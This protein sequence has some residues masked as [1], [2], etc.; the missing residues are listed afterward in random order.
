MLIDAI[1]CA[2]DYSGK[3]AIGRKRDF[4]DDWLNASRQNGQRRG[5]KA[6]RKLSDNQIRWI[7]SQCGKLSQ[8]EMGRRLNVSDPLPKSHRS[9]NH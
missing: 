9:G 4:R 3:K 1:N 6:G 2:R 5:P 8:R 7:R